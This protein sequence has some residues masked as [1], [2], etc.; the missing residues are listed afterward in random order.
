MKPNH[1]RRYSNPVSKLRLI[2]YK[3]IVS[4]GGFFCEPRLT[5]R[6]STPVDLCFCIIKNTGG[7]AGTPAPMPENYGG[8]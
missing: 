6:F 2:G 8:F 3:K 1:H 4:Y 5:H 7:S